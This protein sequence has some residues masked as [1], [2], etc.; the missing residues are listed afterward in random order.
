TGGTLFLLGVLQIS[1][2]T[3]LSRWSFPRRAQKLLQSQFSWFLNQQNTLSRLALGMLNG[4]LPCGLVYMAAI[5]AI[6]VGHPLNG[7]LFMFFFG[8]GTL[9]L[10]VSSLFFGNVMIKRF[11]VNFRRWQAYL[12]AA[13]GVLLIWRGMNFYVPA[14]FHLWQA[15]NFAPRCFGG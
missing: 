2:D 11:G 9:P 13:V 3:L 12:V 14:D 5:G 1:P 4:L 10:L 7:A 6:G 15:I 8:L